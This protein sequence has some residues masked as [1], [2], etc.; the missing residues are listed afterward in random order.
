MDAIT[1][2]TILDRCIAGNVEKMNQL[3]DT[4]SS[5]FDIFYGMCKTLSPR[6]ISDITFSEIGDSKA[7]FKVKT[8][9]SKSPSDL[10]KEV[11]TDNV[12]IV[13]EDGTQS[14]NVIISVHSNY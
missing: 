2:I 11:E 6:S 10:F 8:N 1:K 4:S 3:L 13:P 14:V 7:S 12:E 5:H 9:K